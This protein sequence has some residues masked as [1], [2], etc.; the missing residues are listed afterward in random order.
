MGWEGKEGGGGGC[1]EVE[2][3]SDRPEP[4]PWGTLQHHP[5]GMNKKPVGGEEGG[6]GGTGLN[7]QS[8]T[9]HTYPGGTP[10]TP[11]QA[12]ILSLCGGGGGER[13][14][15][16]YQEVESTTDRPK[17]ILLGTPASTKREEGAVRLRGSGRGRTAGGGGGRVCQGVTG[18][19][20]KPE[21]VPA[22]S[23]VTASCEDEYRTTSVCLYT[24]I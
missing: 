24:Y 21:P 6:H 10:N 8:V 20:D 17:P 22:E 1:Q 13:E 4:V 11:K 14:G 23:L 16:G 2:G 19:P 5:K 15:R 18:T 12:Y 7:R 3:T 9:R